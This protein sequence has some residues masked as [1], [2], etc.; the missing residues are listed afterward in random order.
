MKKIFT[1]VV[2]FVSTLSFAQLKVS[3]VKESE[4]IGEYK[5]L[6]KSY[7]KLEKESTLCFMTY[8]DERFESIDDYKMFVFK[9]SDIDALYDLLTNFEGIEK[10]TKKRV[11]LESGDVL[12]LEYKKM[13]GKMY[14]EIIHIDKAGVMGMMRWLTPKQF[15][16]LFGKA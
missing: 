15:K 13:L 8:R 4:L 14:V 6:G 5:L 7:A 12:S 16:E 1:L 11:E 2:L 9:A 10:G 3:E